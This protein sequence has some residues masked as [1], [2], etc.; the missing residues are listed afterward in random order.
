MPGA[1]LDDRAAHGNESPLKAQ[2]YTFDFAQNVSLP[3]TAR[4]VGPL[5][6][7]TPRKVQLFGI[8]SEAIPKQVNYLLDEA[9]TIGEDGK[10]S[11]NPNTVVSLLHHFFDVYVQDEEECYLNADNCAG[12]NKKQNSYILPCLALSGWPSS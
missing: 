10:K 11:H 2:H 5:Y 8:C 9:D 12:Q 6:F 1:E 4:R 3:H 7:K